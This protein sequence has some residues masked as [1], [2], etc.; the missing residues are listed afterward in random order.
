M[1]TPC[2]WGISCKITTKAKATDLDHLHMDKIATITVLNVAS[3][4]T[5]TVFNLDKVQPDPM[6]LTFNGNHGATVVQLSI[7][8]TRTPPILN[9]NMV[10]TEFKKGKTPLPLRLLDGNLLASFRI[11]DHHAQHTHGKIMELCLRIIVAGQCIGIA[12]KQVALRGKNKIRENLPTGI[13][14]DGTDVSD[15][16][17]GCDDCGDC[18]SCAGGDGSR[19]KMKLSA[20]KTA[21]GKT[22]AGKTAA[23]KTAAGKTAAGKTAAGKAAAGKTAAA[24]KTGPGSPHE[25]DAQG[26]SFCAWIDSGTSPVSPASAAYMMQ[27]EFFSSP[28]AEMQGLM[29]MFD[30]NFDPTSH[31]STNFYVNF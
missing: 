5:S 28:S 15:F 9:L 3:T 23:G 25:F 20:G 12:R 7:V 4:I 10:A 21:A 18:D 19:K 31:F 26:A 22:A 24:D 1:E 30:G 11:N 17:G 29:E 6:T 16:N 27:L 8:D 14:A 2:K 13:N